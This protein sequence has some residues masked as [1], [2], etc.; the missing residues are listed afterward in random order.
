MSL[1][2]TY[3]LPGVTLE[4]VFGSD[5]GSV[6][7]NTRC[8]LFGYVGASCTK[9]LNTPWQ[10]ANLSEVVAAAGATCQLTHIY[11]AARSQNSGADL[12]LIPLAAPAS[13]TA[14]THKVTFMAAPSAGVLG[15]G[16]AALLADTC[17]VR[18]RGRGASFRIAQGDSFSEIASAAA[19]A[20]QAL[21]SLGVTISVASQTVT[22]TDPHKGEHGNDCPISVS[23]ASRGASGVAASCGDVT[24]ATTATGAGV[25][26][27]ALNAQVCPVTIGATNT[28]VQSAQAAVAAI[29][30]NGFCVDAAIPASPADGVVTLFYRDG[31]VAHQIS[32]AI[33]ATSQTCT[34]NCGTVGT[35]TPDLTSALAKLVAAKTASK[36]FACFWQ[37]ASNWGT[38]S[39]HIEDQSVVPIQK[40]QV[41]VGCVTT[42]GIAARAANLPASTTPALTVSPRYVIAH[43]AG[44][45]VAS[46]ELT[47][48]IAAAVAGLNPLTDSQ[49]LNGLVLRTRDGVPLGVPHEIDQV[50][51]EEANTMIATYKLAPLGVVSGSNVLLRSSTTYAAEGS[52]DAKLEK[53]SAILL[54]DYMRDDIRKRV[55]ARHG[56][57]MLKAV[58]QARTSNCTTPLAILDTIYEC[59]LGYDSNDLY[60]D[61]KSLRADFK[62]S[63][64]SANRVRCEVPLRPTADLDQVEIVSPIL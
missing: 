30:A 33:T 29:R 4:E 49:N 45:P 59:L 15:T 11:Q 22:A 55:N 43:Q 7:P 32:A 44:S 58:G 48:R 53:I 27:L 47:A 34:V 40:G 41:A 20:L 24:F 28:A 42:G 10:P 37:D 35:G 8:T 16:T 9:P 18:Y 17:T 36:V 46:W 50:G 3:K 25:A 26:T 21:T 19:S 56:K 52:D 14:A 1:S 6:T 60:D 38:F 5:S 62:F 54:T 57:Q 2:P 31:I 61:A 64:P 12:V 39:S 51:D 23:F 63:V 13:G